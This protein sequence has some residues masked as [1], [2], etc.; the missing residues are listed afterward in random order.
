MSPYPI[1]V[2]L[3]HV[4]IDMDLKAKHYKEALHAN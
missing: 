3:P 2:R 1:P 4:I